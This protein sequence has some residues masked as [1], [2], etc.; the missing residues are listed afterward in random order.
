MSKLNFPAVVAKSPSTA[1]QALGI[2]EG[3]I[4]EYNPA[5]GMYVVNKVEEDI[6]PGERYS[7]FAEAKGFSNKVIQALLESGVVENIPIM[8]IS[9]EDKDIPE[10]PIKEEPIQWETAELMML[11]GRCGATEKVAQAVGGVSLFMPTTSGAETVLACSECG[12]RM[13]LIY[14]NG[15]NLTEAEKDQLKAKQEAQN[16]SSKETLP[17]DYENKDYDSA[18]DPQMNEDD[19]PDLKETSDESQKESE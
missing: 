15:R 9:K 13:S 2:D 17:E 18:D 14:E 11:C 10:S 6:G 7:Y 3:D 5:S 1:L 4:L 8:E 19:V 12:N 16:K